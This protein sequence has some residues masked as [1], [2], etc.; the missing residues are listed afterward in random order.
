MDTSIYPGDATIDWYRLNCGFRYTG[1]YLAPAPLHQNTSWMDRRDHL[2]AQAWG[3]LPVFVGLQI[4]SPNVS[5]SVGAQHGQNATKLMGQA[6]FHSQTICY[7]D[8]EDGTEPA[9]DYARYISA[10]VSA[11]TK[12][13]YAPGI[14]CSH[15]I[16]NWCRE[17]TPYLWTFRLPRG[18]SGQTYPP[19]KI[20]KGL[21]V[22]GGVATQ[23][24][25]NVFI[26][27][28]RTP[29]DLNVSLVADPSNLAS[30]NAALEVGAAIA[31]STRPAAL[32]QEARR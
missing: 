14:Y 29:I 8:L 12:A 32:T 26:R 31:S 28:K 2:A 6:G 25:Q 16:A 20:P 1:F 11:L 18:T 24:R 27:G 15:R 22:G 5:A 4:R 13:N 3:F 23:Y 21:I 17:N 10:W 19:A 9:G 7:L 30:V